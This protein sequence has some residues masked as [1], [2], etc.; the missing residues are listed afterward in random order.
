MLDGSLDADIFSL[1]ADE[2]RDAQGMEVWPAG[3]GCGEKVGKEIRV[4]SFEGEGAE[5]LGRC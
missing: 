5:V 1:P 2:Q 3:G 4:D